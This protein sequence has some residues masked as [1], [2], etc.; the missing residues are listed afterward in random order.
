VVTLAIIVQNTVPLFQLIDIIQLDNENRINKCVKERI[1]AGNKAYFATINYSKIS[2]YPE[3]L[4][5]KYTEQ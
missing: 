4:K 2:S 1:Q 3:A 5:C